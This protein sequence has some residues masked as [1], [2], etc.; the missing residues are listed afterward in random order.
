MKDKNG[1]IVIGVLFIMIIIISISILVPEMMLFYSIK[2]RMDSQVKYATDSA[3]MQVDLVNG[4]FDEV[5]AKKVFEVVIN[6]SKMDLSNF[7]L[8]N[9]ELHVINLVP[10]KKNI[11]GVDYDFVKPTLIGCREIKSNENFTFMKEISI[12]SCIKKE[13][14]INDYVVPIVPNSEKDGENSE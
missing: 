9:Q 11:N 1:S 4:T 13:I 8:V 3:S 10:S 5:N 14:N 2:E 12:R 7:S 6:E